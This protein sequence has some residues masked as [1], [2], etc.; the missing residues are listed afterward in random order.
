MRDTVMMSEMS[1]SEYDRRLKDGALLLLPCGTIEQHAHHLPLGVDK[2]LPTRVCQEVAG[3]LGA[4]VADP[5]V[6]GC[7]SQP[8]MGGG[9]DFVG[10][11]SLD[12]ATYFNVVRDVLREF[13]RHGARRIIVVNGHYENMMFIMEGI[14]LALREARYDDIRDV[15]VMRLEYWD[16]I[17]DATLAT[18]FPEGFPGMALEH[19]AVIETS[20]ML[21]FFPD[22]VDL[23]RMPED[24]APAAFPAYE[25]F[26]SGKRWVP[27][28]GSLS[29]ARGASAENGRLIADDSVSGIVRD[30]A[31]EFAVAPR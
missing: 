14:D 17:R 25:I 21:H 20:L 16:Y 2:L 4:I 5:I 27:P 7:K 9:Q 19:A 1:W 28:S 31:A 24:E 30:I 3:R 15:T 11:T 10:T 8:K 22:L 12:G 13:M 26:P 23:S 18:V 6:Y 29:P